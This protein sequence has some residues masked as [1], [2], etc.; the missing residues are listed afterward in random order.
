METSTYQTITDE[1]GKVFH[2]VPELLTLMDKASANALAD[3]VWDGHA[4]PPGCS[5]CHFN[6]KERRQSPHPARDRYE[7]CNSQTGGIIHNHECGERKVIFVSP[8]N[9]KRYQLRAVTARL[10]GELK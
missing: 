7:H 5:A 9:L 3:A 4:Y 2:I 8:R 10:T 1:D 6:R